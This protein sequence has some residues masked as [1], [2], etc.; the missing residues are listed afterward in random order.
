MN[1]YASG[2]I[3][4][5]AL[6]HGRNMTDAGICRARHNALVKRIKELSANE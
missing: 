5:I 1:D 3:E 4:E 6:V 2:D